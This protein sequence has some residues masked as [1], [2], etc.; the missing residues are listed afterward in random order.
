MKIFPSIYSIPKF[1]KCKYYNTNTN[2][3]KLSYDIAISMYLDSSKFKKTYFRENRTSFHEM[4]NK[5]FESLF[6]NGPNT[7]HRLNSGVIYI[8]PSFYYTIS[9]TGHMT[10]NANADVVYLKPVQTQ[11]N[12]STLGLDF[13]ID[14]EVTDESDIV[15]PKTWSDE[16]NM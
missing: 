9:G 2:T 4:D 10:V 8:S 14:D 5:T 11:I 13:V 16:E 7:N 3:N 1:K 15:H 6:Y 12:T